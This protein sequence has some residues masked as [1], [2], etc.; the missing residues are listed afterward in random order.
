MSRILRPFAFLVAAVIALRPAAVMS[1]TGTSQ[2]L[3]QSAQQP[4]VTAPVL[5]AGEGRDTFIQVCGQCHSPDI[6]ANKRPARDSW[7]GVIETMVGRGAVATDEQ[8]D[9]IENYLTKAFPSD[10][11]KD[12]PA[13]QNPKE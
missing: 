8:F 2:S 3:S 10:A 9:E 6:V 7:H 5:P 1:Q 4:G 12:A 11:A 13:S